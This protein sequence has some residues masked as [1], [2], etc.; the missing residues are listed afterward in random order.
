M[1][2]AALWVYVLTHSLQNRFYLSGHALA[3]LG[4][5]ARAGRRQWS[6][7][8]EGGGSAEVVTR[9]ATQQQQQLVYCDVCVFVMRILPFPSVVGAD[10]FDD[11]TKVL[12]IKLI[13]FLSHLLALCPHHHPTPHPTPPQARPFRCSAKTLASPATP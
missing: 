13:P 3:S 12:P 7:G 6:C 9:T 4:A 8:G 10:S 11:A 5:S 2:V 1:V